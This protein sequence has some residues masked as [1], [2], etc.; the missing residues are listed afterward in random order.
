MHKNLV[1]DL[2]PYFIVR[3]KIKKFDPANTRFCTMPHFFLL[4]FPAGNDG[5]GSH[6][7]TFEWGASSIE[8][9]GNVGINGGIIIIHSIPLSPRYCHPT[10]IKNKP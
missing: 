10:F 5:T 1:G 6:G 9:N 4:L 3:I 7:R 8:L 2:A